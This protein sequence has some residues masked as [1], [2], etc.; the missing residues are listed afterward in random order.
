MKTINIA[1]EY[2]ITP[3]ARYITDGEFSGQDFREKFL[4]PVFLDDSPAKVLVILDGTMG[5]ATSFLEE[6]FGGLVRK[7]GN[8]FTNKAIFDKFEFISN[9]EPAC[10]EEIKKYIMEAKYKSL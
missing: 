3:G 8:K 5:Y 7:L 9:E 2:T 4:E 10:I 6:S 1:Q